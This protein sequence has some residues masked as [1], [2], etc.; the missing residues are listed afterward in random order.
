MKETTEQQ[1]LLVYQMENEI[2]CDRW[3]NTKEGTNK[4][5]KRAFRRHKQQIKTMRNC[6]TVDNMQERVCDDSEEWNFKLNQA[7]H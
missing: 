4:P 2:V 6:T 7:F 1:A 3:T 5:V